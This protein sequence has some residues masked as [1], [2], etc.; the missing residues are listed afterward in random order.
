MTAPQDHTPLPIPNGWFAVAWSRELVAGEAT[1]IRYFD[2][3]MVLFRT[4]SGA[5]KVLDAYC[6]HLGAHL[7]EG[8]RVMGESIRFY[9]V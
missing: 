9:G 3:E 2:H 7:G 1:R 5:A 6:A 8:G 4:R